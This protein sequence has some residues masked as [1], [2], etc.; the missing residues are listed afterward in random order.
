[1]LVK[2]EEKDKIDGK[3]KEIASSLEDIQLGDRQRDQIR[4]G[5]P[6]TVSKGDTEVTIG[7]DLDTISG[8]RVIKGDLD[9]WRQRKMV[10]WDRLTPG[11]TGYWQTAENGWEYTKEQEKYRTQTEQERHRGG[12]T[13]RTRG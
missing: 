11:A 10:E 5:Q 6:V 8:I 13:G 7:V 4:N 9:D 3:L 12:G 2:K 1:M